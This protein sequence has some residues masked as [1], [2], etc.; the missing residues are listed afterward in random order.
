MRSRAARCTALVDGVVPRCMQTSPSE[1]STRPCE[2]CTVATSDVMVRMPHCQKQWAYT[3]LRGRIRYWYVLRRIA[4]RDKPLSP[5]PE[6]ALRIKLRV[7]AVRVVMISL[8]A[9]LR[10][11]YETEPVPRHHGSSVTPLRRCRSGPR[12]RRETPTGPISRFMRR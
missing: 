2:P 9:T 8:R 7:N 11:K 10:K 4:N 3:G 5:W 12:L 1:S 6:C